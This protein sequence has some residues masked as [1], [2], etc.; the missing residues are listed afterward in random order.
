MLYSDQMVK[1]S[2]SNKKKN[3]NSQH[4]PD[5]DNEVSD[6]CLLIVTEIDLIFHLD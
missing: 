1:I 4:T 3:N 2:K 5:L 6:L